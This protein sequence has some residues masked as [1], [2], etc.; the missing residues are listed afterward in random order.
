MHA[1]LRQLFWF[2][3]RYF[4]SGEKPF[5][6]KPLNRKILI[7]VGVLFSG[8]GLV[9]AYFA[10]GQAQVGYLIPVVVF[11]TVAF[12]CLVVGLLGSDRAVANIWGNR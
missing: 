5:N 4:E 12:V 1:L 8:L 2:V 6:Y 10:M 9:S 7:V 11:F 3:L